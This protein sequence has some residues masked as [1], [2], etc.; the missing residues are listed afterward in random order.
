M[1]FLHPELGVHAL[2]REG[3]PT[4]CQVWQQ[5]LWMSFSDVFAANCWPWGAHSS[6]RNCSRERV[7]PEHRTV[8]SA[9]EPESE[10]RAPVVALPAHN[11]LSDI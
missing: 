11:S 7:R 6:T 4:L 8:V 1:E 2:L 3:G 10:T 9:L 5:K